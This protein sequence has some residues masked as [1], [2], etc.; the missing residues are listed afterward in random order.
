M[1]INDISRDDSV[2]N[3]IARPEYEA[4][5]AEL[6]T[7]IISLETKLDKLSDKMDTM[8]TNMASQISAV[9]LSL[10]KNTIQ[11]GAVKFVGYTVVNLVTGAGVYIL[12]QYIL[13]GRI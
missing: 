2:T 6:Q 1:P 11:I 12:A 5:Q 9:N 3:F 10:S 13:T 7:R 8:T 4:R